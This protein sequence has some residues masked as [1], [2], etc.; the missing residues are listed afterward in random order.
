MTEG[1]ITRGCALEA[2]SRLDR[3][4]AGGVAPAKDSLADR[5]DRGVGAFNEHP[6]G[7]CCA[8]GSQRHAQHPP[9][10]HRRTSSN[11]IQPDSR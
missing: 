2:A 4:S 11:R 5:R 3:D 6:P 9:R 1:H 8:P 7:G 10:R